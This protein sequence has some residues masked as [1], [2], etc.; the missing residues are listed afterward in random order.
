M[1]VQAE[2]RVH[3]IGQQDSVNVQY[4]IARNTADD[5]IWYNHSRSRNIRVVQNI[6]FSSNC[7]LNTVFVFGQMCSSSSSFFIENVSNAQ[8][9]TITYKTSKRN[10][11]FD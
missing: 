1:L 8:T 3:R 4:L 2:D 5:Y 11:R 6:L 7:S 10:K 9:H